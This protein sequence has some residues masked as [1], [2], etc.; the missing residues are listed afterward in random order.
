MGFPKPSVDSNSFR[1]SCSSGWI[2]TSNPPVNSCKR[3]KHTGSIV[4][5]PVSFAVDGLVLYVRGVD[6]ADTAYE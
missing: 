3:R 6:P 5:D 1:R 2:R 4:N